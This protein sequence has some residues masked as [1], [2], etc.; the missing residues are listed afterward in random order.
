MCVSVNKNKPTSSQIGIVYTSARACDVT[1]RAHKRIWTQQPP[2]H[3]SIYCHLP[4][5]HKDQD[6]I[7]MKSETLVLVVLL[8]VVYMS[9]S[10]AWICNPHNCPKRMKK[11]NQQVSRRSIK[12]GV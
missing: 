1:K 9:L 7:E 8:V 11:T 4:K 12:E 3:L 6:S 2:A 5:V 10:Q